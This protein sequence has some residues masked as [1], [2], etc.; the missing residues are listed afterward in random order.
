[1]ARAAFMALSSRPYLNPKHRACTCIPP[2]RKRAP[3]EHLSLNLPLSVPP[4]CIPGVA[5]ENFNCAAVQIGAWLGDGLPP[6]APP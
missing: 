2:S 3:R 1:M 5:L 6:A 4:L